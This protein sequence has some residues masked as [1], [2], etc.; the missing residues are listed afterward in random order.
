MNRVHALM[1][2]PALALLAAGGVAAAADSP[3]KLRS[4]MATAERQYVDLYN[5][6]NTERQFDIVCRMDKPTGTTFAVRVCQPR[7][8][9]RAKE[10]SA[11]ERMQAAVSAA[12]STGAANSGGPNVGAG[13][14]VAGVSAAPDMDEA[15]RQN[16]LAVQQRSA[17][18][19]ALGAKRDELQSRYDEA[20][21]GKGSGR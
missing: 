21:K 20:M 11:T 17:E 5:K 6:L 4:E 16:L 1:M 19:R 8:L 12:E 10:K 3:N 2:L 14:S 13:S 15:F 9:L 18:L 7:Y